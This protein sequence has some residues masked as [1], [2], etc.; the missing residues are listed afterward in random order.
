M[1]DFWLEIALVLGL[2]GVNAVLA[3]S[4]IAFVTLRDAQI[5]RLERRNAAG[6]LAAALA[7][8]P[9]RF[10]ATVQIGITLAGFLA[11]ATAAVSIAE[12]LVEPLAFFGRAAEPVAIV[13]VTLA[14]SYLSLVFGE[15]APKR[16]ALQR[17]ERWVTV[18]ARPLV[19]I[20][21]LARPITCDHAHLNL[22][23]PAH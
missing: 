14:L 10:L 12:P 5:D 23:R 6:R 15:L 7:R 20:A 17:A 18:F 19:I 2:V 13:L 9:N 3:G 4:E 1:A 21:S 16:V 11:S 22:P 8:D